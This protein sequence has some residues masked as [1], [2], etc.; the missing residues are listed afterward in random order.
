MKLILNLNNTEY[1]DI[2]LYK[3]ILNISIF[4]QKKI[5]KQLGLNFLKI[6][7]NLFFE[8]TK[9]KFLYKKLLKIFSYILIN[10]NFYLFIQNF[11]KKFLKQTF[12]KKVIRLQK[13][14]PV[15]GQR[16]KT[17]SRNAR[18]KFFLKY[19]NKILN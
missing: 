17:N 5:V 6:K 11:Y 2:V 13:G 7:K 1:N 8:L 19:I 3:K 12:L 9:N 14:L 16:T 10:K 15:N 18:K 4:T